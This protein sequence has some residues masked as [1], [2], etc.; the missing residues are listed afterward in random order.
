MPL[1]E[2]E[3]QLI[4]VGVP[5]PRLGLQR[6][7]EGKRKVDTEEIIGLALVF[8]VPPV[9]LMFPFHTSSDP[10]V[11]VTGTDQ[12]P[13][14][15]VDTRAALRWFA[16][17]GTLGDERPS[18]GQVQLR[19][20][21]DHDRLVDEVG[22]LDSEFRLFPAA[23]DDPEKKVAERKLRVAVRDLRVVRGQLRQWHLEPPTLDEQLAF[24][25]DERAEWLP[26]GDAQAPHGAQGLS[27]L[28]ERRGDGSVQPINFSD[29][30]K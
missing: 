17:R 11:L 21:D 18:P 22:Y 14:R 6:L 26:P 24:V 13:A 29:R 15:V 8:N 4:A 23:Y 20:L 25:D 3:R 2:L 27:I 5:I 1:T 28:V 30:D 9:M 16:G 12:V 19:L 10:T 7:E